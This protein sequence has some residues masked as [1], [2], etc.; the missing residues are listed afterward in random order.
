MKK[1]TTKYERD[2]L[3][4]QFLGQTG[5]SSAPSS[6]VEKSSHIFLFTLILMVTAFFIWAAMGELDVVSRAQGEVVPSTR[7]KTIQHL[8]G[9]IIGKILVKEGEIVKKGLPLVILKSTAST[10]DVAEQIIRMRSLEIKIRR[11][12]AEIRGKKSLDFTGEMRRD[13][14]ELT[15]RAVEIFNTRRVRF[16]SQIKVQEELINQYRFQTEEIKARLAGTTHV[17]TFIE[18]Q[19]AISEKLLKQSLSNRMNHIDLLKQL[20]DLKFKQKVDKAGM[21]RVE[22]AI[23]EAEN[24]LEVVKSTFLEEAY[25][26]FREAKRT[27]DILKERIHKD[28]DSLKRT[29]LRSPVDGTV[30]SL[31]VATIGGILPPGGAVADIVPAEDR[32]II[33]ARLPIGDIGYVQIGQEVMIRLASFNA[34]RLGQ[35]K[36]KVSHISPD[37]IIQKEESPFYKIKITTSLNYFGTSETP[38]HLYPGVLVQ[39]SIVTGSRTVLEYLIEPF[40]MS[41]NTALLER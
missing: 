8:E 6:F 20:A 31:F 25:D 38:Y 23:K 17:R 12:D 14:P 40:M 13:E 30:K 33:E 21:K 9:G 34:S 10:A 16:N 5:K 1:Q 11:L 3:N 4:N 15:Q 24:R 41:L 22:S 32:L 29:I 26:D 7:V 18:E 39:C 19:T 36:G 27:L 2:L 28:E 37:S 35:I